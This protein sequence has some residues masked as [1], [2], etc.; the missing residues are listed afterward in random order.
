MWSKLSVEGRNWIGSYL[1]IHGGVILTSWSEHRGRNAEI[2]PRLSAE[3]NTL[4]HLETTWKQ[5]YSPRAHLAIFI[6]AEPRSFRSLPSAPNI[7]SICIQSI[8]IG[9]VDC[10]RRAQSGRGSVTV[11]VV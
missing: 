10:L 7:D 5:H 3:R 2:Q 1:G 4:S 9:V 6:P 11:S 8:G